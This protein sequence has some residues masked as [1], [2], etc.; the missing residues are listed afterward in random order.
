MVE[1]IDG[2]WFVVDR[3]G[4][5]LAGPFNDKGRAEDRLE[6]LARQANIRRRRCITCG[7]EFNSQGVGNRMCRL[8]RE[9]RTVV[10]AQ[11]EGA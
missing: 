1:R 11:F 2:R 3:R 8:C 6:N 7:A 5:R 10:S 4:R 9:G